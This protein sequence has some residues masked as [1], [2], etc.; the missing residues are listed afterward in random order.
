MTVPSLTT[1]YPSLGKSLAARKRVIGALMMREIH[2]RFGRDNVGYLW[3]FL[4]PGLLGLGISAIHYTLGSK[5]P[6]GMQVVPF[7]LAGYSAFCMFRAMIN[8][9]LGAVESNAA[10]FYH[11]PVTVLDV[12]AARNL[13]ELAA[14]MVA[15]LC[16][17][18]ISTAIGWGGL[19]T[20]PLLFIEGWGLLF[21]TGLGPAMYI[22]AASVRWPM[23][24]RF[25]HP[26]VY[27]TMPLSGVFL[28]FS[29]LRGLQ[30]IVMAYSP[31]AHCMELVR[32]GVFASYNSPGLDVPFILKVAGVNCLLGLLALRAVR[33]YIELP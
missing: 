29:Q 17:L 15:A 3:L 21:I 28:C 30:R 32:E 19:P 13:L 9:A 20:R 25:V 31:T 4:E 10:L 18:G 11:R 2:T 5:V 12:I 7:Y 33:R 14:C 6:F 16:L 1:N 23:I 8:R 26:L 27:L 22:T 24:E